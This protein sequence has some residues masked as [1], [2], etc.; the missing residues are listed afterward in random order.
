[1]TLKEYLIDYAS[2]ETRKIG[3]ALIEKEIDNIGKPE[4]RPKVREELK[5][6][7]AEL[8]ICTSNKKALQIVKPFYIK[9]FITSPA[10]I[11]P[12]TGGTNALLPGICLRTLHFLFVSGGQMQ[13]SSLHKFSVVFGFI[14][15]SF[16]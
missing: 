2:P 16:E 5:K 14:G 15:S 4:L 13:F 7:K 8:E 9:S 12:T 11:S 3:E 6:M 1:M 10:I